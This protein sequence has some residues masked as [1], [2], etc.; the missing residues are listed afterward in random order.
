LIITI[1]LPSSLSRIPST[2]FFV[3]KD[4]KV[5]V[6]LHGIQGMRCIMCHGDGKAQSCESSNNTGDKKGF[7]F[8]LK[9]GINNMKKHVENEHTIDLA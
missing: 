3:V 4:Y 7:T 2:C 6:D 8:N 1:N 5:I 9:H